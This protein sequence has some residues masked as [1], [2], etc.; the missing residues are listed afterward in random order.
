MQ[1]E[2]NIYMELPGADLGLL[3]DCFL[4][5]SELDTLYRGER[6]D[7]FLTGKSKKSAMEKCIIH[8]GDL[9]NDALFFLKSDLKNHPLIAKSLW[10]KN[11][12]Q[13][14]ARNYL[15]SN[16]DNFWFRFTLA[17]EDYID[18]VKSMR[19]LT[20]IINHLE[21]HIIT[22][23][24]NEYALKRRNV[25]PDRLPIG[26][27]IYIDHIYGE[28]AFDLHERAI[29]VKKS[30]EPIGTLFVSKKGLF[31]GENEQDIQA[32]N[33]LEII[34]AAHDVLPLYKDIF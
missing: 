24:T 4:K 28:G 21:P 13:I 7:W 34:L 12:T 2:F 3:L 14:I 33:D 30:D 8:E 17:K 15:C 1:I 25:F 10:S 27:I 9:T 32:A 26:W 11:G 19:I 29:N 18:V 23:E 5:I 6:V 20:K 22:V 31:D 16:F